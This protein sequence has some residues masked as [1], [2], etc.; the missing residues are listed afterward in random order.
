MHPMSQAGGV[1]F[2]RWGQRKYD[3]LRTRPS[4][5]QKCFSS[6]KESGEVIEDIWGIESLWKAI[7]PLRKSARATSCGVESITVHLFP[8]ACLSRERRDQGR[9]DLRRASQRRKVF[10]AQP[11][12]P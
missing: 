1:A 7:I 4:I 12:V 6:Y 10:V 3:W 5:F 2:C 8:V 11:F 9:L